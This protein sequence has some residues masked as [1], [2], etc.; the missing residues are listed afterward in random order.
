ML[1]SFELLS[2]NSTNNTFLLRYVKL[3]WLSTRGCSQH[4]WCGQVMLDLIKSH[5]FLCPPL[6]CPEVNSASSFSRSM[7]VKEINLPD[8]FAINLSVFFALARYR[9][10]K[11]TCSSSGVVL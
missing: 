4:W 1:F 3:K 8:R 11:I 5:F 7:G 2:Q 6:P 10:V 9:V